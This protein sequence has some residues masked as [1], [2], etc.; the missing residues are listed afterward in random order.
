MNEYETMLDSMVDKKKPEQIFKL[1]KK[2]LR[3]E[4][5]KY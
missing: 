3:T 2:Q 1:T 5:P 4:D